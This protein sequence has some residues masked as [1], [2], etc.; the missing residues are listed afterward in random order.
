MEECSAFARSVTLRSPAEACY[1]ASGPVR[2]SH[3]SPLHDS[4]P[5]LPSGSHKN[6]DLIV[7][8]PDLVFCTCDELWS[9]N[10][11]PG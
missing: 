5:P 3:K 10:C 1:L 11:P 7:I 6:K 9:N 2:L 4:S 8:D